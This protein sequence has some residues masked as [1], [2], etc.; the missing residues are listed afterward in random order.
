[1]RTDLLLLLSWAWACCGRRVRVP[2]SA[3][4]GRSLTFAPAAYRRSAAPLRRGCILACVQEPASACC[5]FTLQDVAEAIKSGNATNVIVMAGAGISVSA[6]IPDFRT[7]GSGLYDNLEEYGLPYP[8]AIFRL[9]YF[10]E[11]PNPFYRLCSE[12]W[13]GNY[14]PTPTHHFI[15]LLHKKGVLRRCYTQNIDSLETAAGL[16]SEALVAAHG[17]FDTASVRLTPGR[18]LV[19]INEVRQAAAAEGMDGWSALNAKYGNATLG[20]LV[21]PDIVFFGEDLPQRFYDLLDYD[22]LACDMLLVLGTSL[23]VNPFAKLIGAVRAEIP[24]FLINRN[25]VAEASTLTNLLVEGRGG[26]DF[27][28][29][30]RDGFYQGDC[31]DAVRELVDLLGWQKDFAELLQGA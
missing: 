16:P 21:K 11:N 2:R 29:S 9:A 10:L 3:F 30:S 13:P 8:E 14:K 27:D 20:G 15:R 18:G 31:D 17:N 28:G 19:P 4:T 6:G 25:R 12:L 22:F 7:P 5:T 23:A 26:F 1:M 24:R